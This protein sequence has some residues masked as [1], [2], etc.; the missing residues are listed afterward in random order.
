M[1]IQSTQPVG[2]GYDHGDGDGLLTDAQRLDCYRIAC[3]M[4]AFVASLLPVLSRAVRDQVDRASLSVVLNTAEGAGRLSPRDKARF[5]SIARG[6]ANETVA[7][8]DVMAAE[9]GDG[10]GRLSG[11]LGDGPCA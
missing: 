1:A 10:Y 9:T 2:D 5:Y 4:R 6:S 7:L 3:E 11:R 8:L